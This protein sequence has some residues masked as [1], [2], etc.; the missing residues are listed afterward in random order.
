MSR[1]VVEM[2]VL[3]W[4]DATRRAFDA[5]ARYKFW[6]FGYHAG[7]VV[8]LATLVSRAGGP[9]MQNPFTA[10][11]HHARRAYCRACGEMRDEQHRCTSESIAWTDQMELPA[12]ETPA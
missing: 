4:E 10:L 11:V 9:K 1:E 3:E 12:G 8:Y 6:M 2:L 7:R 5:L